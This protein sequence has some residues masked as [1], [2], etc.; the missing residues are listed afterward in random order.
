[1]RL[2]QDAPA[3]LAEARERLGF[4]RLQ[5][6]R[7]TKRAGYRVTE[8]TIFNIEKGVSKRPYPR[9]IYALAAAYGMDA[10]DLLE[11]AS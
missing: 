10:D 9:T 4:S 1:M 2:L 5:V 8:A 7:L 11:R 3:K 6:E